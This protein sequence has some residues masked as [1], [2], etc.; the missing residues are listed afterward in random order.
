MMSDELLGMMMVESLNT[1]FFELKI[2]T[3]NDAAVE[4]IDRG[5]FE[6]VS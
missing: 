2:I 4:F 3:T 5:E 1:Y 6:A